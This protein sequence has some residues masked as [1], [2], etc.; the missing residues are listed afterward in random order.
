MWENFCG[1]QRVKCCRVLS[2]HCLDVLFFRW[3]DPPSAARLC[4]KTY[5]TISDVTYHLLP[6]ITP[7]PSPQELEVAT[8]EKQVLIEDTA[9]D[10]INQSVDAVIHMR[11]RPRHKRFLVHKMRLTLHA[12][13]RNTSRRFAL[14]ASNV[15][16]VGANPTCSVLAL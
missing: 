5:S 8:P 3:M 12:T 9:Y 6:D 16:L 14:G 15:C 4:R 11:E 2:R 13:R 7:P 10:N 1:S